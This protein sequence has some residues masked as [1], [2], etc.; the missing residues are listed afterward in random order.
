M[1]ALNIYNAKAESRALSM[2]VQDRDLLDI[3]QPY[4]R[5]SVWGVARKQN[6]IK[7]LL[8]G[9]P[10]GAIVINDRF[11]AH[12]THDGYDD[13]RAN[14]LAIVDGKQRI[15]AIRD[16]V[17]GNFSVPGAWFDVDSDSVSFGKLDSATQ[18]AFLRLP[19]AV[20]VGKLPTM[21]QEEEMFDL[22]N[23]GG[24]PQGETDLD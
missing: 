5:G 4:Q 12:F 24:V 11:Q 2:L 22:I 6:L 8:M 9:I 14:R 3:D 1:M 20:A 7:S 15:T 16:F 10:V 23:F 13:D 18:R 21:A 19:I 17:D